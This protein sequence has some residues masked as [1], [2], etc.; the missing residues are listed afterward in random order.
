MDFV[1]NFSVDKPHI[2]NIYVNFSAM[3]SAEKFRQS[4]KTLCELPLFPAYMCGSRADA[5]VK[6][7]AH[8]TM[9]AQ[10]AR[11]SKLIVKIIG[12]FFVIVYIANGLHS[13]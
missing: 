6:T 10:A 13:E 2:N 3:K 7:A 1:D 8:R 5:D 11:R 4:Y 9:S 12:C